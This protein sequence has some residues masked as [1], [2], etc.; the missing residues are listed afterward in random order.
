M[1]LIISQAF[2]AYLMFASKGG[3]YMKCDL[4]LGWLLALPTK[5]KPSLLISVDNAAVSLSNIFFFAT[6]VL[7]N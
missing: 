5:N 2:P 3:D 4:L 6:E 7:E 1:L